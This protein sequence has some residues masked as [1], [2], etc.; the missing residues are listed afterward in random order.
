MKKLLILATILAA[1]TA[2]PALKKLKL[3]WDW[4]G[5]IQ[6]QNFYVHM[7]TDPFLPLTNW[8]AIAF[9]QG[10]NEY[11]I[12]PLQQ[13]AFYY[14]TATNMWGESD[15]SNTATASSAPRGPTVLRIERAQ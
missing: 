1:M 13:K 11:R 9:V 5:P 8:P 14:V 6:E 10:T 15:P 4:T 12:E 2:S 3:V 7:S